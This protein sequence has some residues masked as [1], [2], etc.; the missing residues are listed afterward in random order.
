MKYM[1]ISGLM[2]R[3]RFCVCKEQAQG[4][5]ARQIFLVD[6]DVLVYKFLR[7]TSLCRLIKLVIIDDEGFTCFFC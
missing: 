1:H 2:D 6:E 5:E 3:P 4:T 7:H